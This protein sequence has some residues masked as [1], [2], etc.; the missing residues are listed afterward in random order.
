MDFIVDFPRIARV[1]VRVNF[2]LYREMFRRNGTVEYRA[3]FKTLLSDACVFARHKISTTFVVNWLRSIEYNTAALIVSAL[4][5]FSESILSLD[6]GY[7]DKLADYID[8]MDTTLTELEMFAGL[9]REIKSIF[10][11]HVCIEFLQEPSAFQDRLNIGPPAGARRITARSPDV[12]VSVQPS[13]GVRAVYYLVG[14]VGA[15]LVAAA[16]YIAWEYCTQTS[17]QNN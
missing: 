10:K 4:S 9:E 15:A 11:D 12:L 8:K 2:S 14:F 1:Y 13:M 16:S 6:N 3:A 17:Q 7:I 5:N